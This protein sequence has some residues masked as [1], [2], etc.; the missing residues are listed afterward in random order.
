MGGRPF[1]GRLFTIIIFLKQLSIA[2]N[3]CYSNLLEC[4]AGLNFNPFKYVY[5]SVAM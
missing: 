3:K 5:D 1:E 2:V 4:K